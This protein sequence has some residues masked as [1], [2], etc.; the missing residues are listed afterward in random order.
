MYFTLF[1]EVLVT[2]RHSGGE[3]KGLERSFE[4]EV[5]ST[6]NELVFG[7]LVDTNA[8]WIA[9]Q[10]TEQGARVRRMTCVGDQV[11]DIVKAIEGGLLEARDLIVMTGGLGP[12]EDDLTIEALAQVAHKEAIYGPRA[13]ELLAASCEAAGIEVTERRKRMARSVEGAEP[14][15]NGVGLAPG[16]QLR[17]GSTVLVALPGIPKEMMPMF[18]RFVLPLIA[19]ASVKR[20]LALKAHLL[21][22][23]YHS[24]PVLSTLRNL[25][26]EAYIKTH[27]QPPSHDRAPDK[28]YGMMVD[29]LVWG[30]T[31]EECTAR[32]EEVT[33]RLRE[34][35]AAAGGQVTIETVASPRA[36]GGRAR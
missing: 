26:P 29:I 34:L 2:Q 19:E 9:K 25:F 32:R 30:T 12:S 27:S 22:P 6:G 7:Q 14:L 4:V 13:V 5:L 17:V 28:V 31:E 36:S 20:A 11:E 33:A 21:M 18:T 15:E 23:Y 24:F 1:D 3:V 10:A 16:V 35:V 8:S